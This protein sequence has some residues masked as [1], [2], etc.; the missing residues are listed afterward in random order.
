[1]QYDM[2]ASDELTSLKLEVEELKRSR[3]ALRRG[4]FA[5]HDALLK[6]VIALQKEPQEV[7]AIKAKKSKK[8]ELVP[9]FGELLE[10]TK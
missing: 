3:D 6:T 9:F 8:A 7:K 10:L 4:I 5:R 1:M 2:F